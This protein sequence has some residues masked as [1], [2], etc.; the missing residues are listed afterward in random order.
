MHKRW[1]KGK[2]HHC[3][4]LILL[5]VVDI[6][7]NIQVSSMVLFRWRSYIYFIGYKDDNNKI[8]PLHNIN[9][10]IICF[11]ITPRFW[12]HYALKNERLCKKLGLWNWMDEFLK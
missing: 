7:G 6:D 2:F 5:E 3:K 1:V 4:N 12:K 8:K 11:Y 9:F 10:T